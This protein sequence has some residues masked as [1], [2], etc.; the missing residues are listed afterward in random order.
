[1]PPGV[2]AVPFNVVFCAVSTP[3]V[4]LMVELSGDTKPFVP[5]APVGIAF[6]LMAVARPFASTVSVIVW[7]ASP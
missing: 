2:I 7:V 5:A 6:A 4:A 1:V 3:A